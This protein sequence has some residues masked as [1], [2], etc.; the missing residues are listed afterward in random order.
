MQ[1]AHQCCCPQCPKT[2]TSNKWHISVSQETRTSVFCRLF[3]FQSSLVLSHLCVSECSCTIEPDDVEEQNESIYRLLIVKQTE[4][5]CSPPQP[6][7]ANRGGSALSFSYERRGSDLKSAAEVQ[8]RMVSFFEGGG[9]WRWRGELM[10]FSEHI[11]TANVADVVLRQ[12]LHPPSR[13]TLCITGHHLLFSDREEGS[14]RQV[15]LLLRNIDAIEKR[16]G[17]RTEIYIWSSG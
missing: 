6:E 16:W 17:G 4:R 10:E 2:F 13:G 3:F 7:W 15:L 8:Q 5:V 14:S 1:Q 9:L 12:P 11:K